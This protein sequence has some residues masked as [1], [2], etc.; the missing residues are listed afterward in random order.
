MVLTLPLLIKTFLSCLCLIVGPCSALSNKLLVSNISK[1]FK[2][3]SFLSNIQTITAFRNVSFELYPKEILCLIGDSGSGK[4]TL[5][6][7]IGFVDSMNISYGDIHIATYSAEQKFVNDPHNSESFRISCYLGLQY[8]EKFHSNNDYC[9]QYFNLSLISQLTPLKDAYR[10]LDMESIDRNT[11]IASLLESKRILFNIFLEI[12]H[13][14][15][16]M[17]NLPSMTCNVTFDNFSNNDYVSPSLNVM[18]IVILDEY[19]DKLASSIRITVFKKLRSLFSSVSTDVGPAGVRNY[20]WTGIAITHSKGVLN[21]CNSRT[22]IMNKGRLYDI[23][24][25]NRKL[26]FPAQLKLIE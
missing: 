25:D 1:L 6:R 14:F 2:K 4:S 7:C 17:L 11:K 16:T 10:L 9:H 13:S 22:A 23:K 12:Q 19:L 18:I 21:D 8:R 3:K 15:V 24:A 26:S 20:E 5:A